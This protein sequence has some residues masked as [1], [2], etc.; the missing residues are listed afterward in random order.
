MSLIT[1]E[2]KRC[3]ICGGNHNWKTCDSSAKS[4]QIVKGTTHLQIKVV[5]ITKMNQKI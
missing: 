4:L 1:V 5:H 2:A 3:S